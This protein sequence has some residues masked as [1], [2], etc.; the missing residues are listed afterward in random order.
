MRRRSILR[1]YGLGSGGGTGGAW[2]WAATLSR[3][4]PTEEKQPHRHSN[5][6]IQMNF[7][8]EQTILVDHGTFGTRVRRTY[9]P[10]PDTYARLEGIWVCVGVPANRKSGTQDTA[11]HRGKDCGKGQE[12]ITE[13]NQPRR[14]RGRRARPTANGIMCPRP[15]PHVFGTPLPARH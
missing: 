2:G 8:N 5:N 15:S 10:P 9:F 1:R 13:N 4:A 6:C 7:E 14:E 12:V 3:P 11:I